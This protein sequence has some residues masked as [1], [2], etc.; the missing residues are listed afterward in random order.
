MPVATALLASLAL[1]RSK[2]LAQLLVQKSL[3]SL[4]DLPLKA[5]PKLLAEP[6]DLSRANFFH[7]V[8]SSRP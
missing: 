1:P 3:D 8:T 2:R 4:V 6:G 7:G 5:C